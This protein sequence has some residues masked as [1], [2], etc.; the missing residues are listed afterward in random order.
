MDLETALTRLTPAARAVFVL[1]EMEGYD[2]AEIS[3][4]T[5]TSE[6]ALRAQLY[7]ARRQIMEV[8]RA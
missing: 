8:L 1:H 5:G 4:L 2:Y 6:T 3:R 7:R